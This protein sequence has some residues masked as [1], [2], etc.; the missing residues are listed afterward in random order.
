MKCIYGSSSCSRSIWIVTY[1][2]RVTSTCSSLAIHRMTLRQ[3][4]TLFLDNHTVHTSWE[5]KPCTVTVPVRQKCRWQAGSEVKTS[6]PKFILMFKVQP[7]KH[8]LI[9]KNLT[10]FRDEAPLFLA[11]FF[12]LT[13]NIGKKH[14]ENRHTPLGHA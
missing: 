12:S 5:L 11:W 2:L 1:S 3:S 6:N 4:A 13:P 8:V 7:P 10:A 9:L 14:Q